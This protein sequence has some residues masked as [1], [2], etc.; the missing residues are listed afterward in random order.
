MSSVKKYPFLLCLPAWKASG[1]SWLP[2]LLSAN[3]IYH[4]V[5]HSQGKSKLICTNAKKKESRV[6]EEM[7]MAL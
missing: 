7:F 6:L 5:P 3:P 4:S 2:E 1:C